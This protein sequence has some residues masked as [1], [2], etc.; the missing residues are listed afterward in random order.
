M[1]ARM[2]HRTLAFI[3]K[4]MDRIREWHSTLALISKSIDRIREWHSTFAFILKSIDRHKKTPG[5]C[6]LDLWLHLEVD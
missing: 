5:E 2:R 1:S 4:S 6:H 3:L